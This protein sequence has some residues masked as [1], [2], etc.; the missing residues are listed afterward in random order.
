MENEGYI[1]LLVY[2]DDRGDLV[3]YRTGETLRMATDGEGRVNAGSSGQGFLQHVRTS[4]L[5]SNAPST[6]R[7][8]EYICECA[9]DPNVPPS[10]VAAAAQLFGFDIPEVTR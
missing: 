3:T 6:W 8:Y 1:R 9:V 7:Q 2:V 4:T 5:R 10:K